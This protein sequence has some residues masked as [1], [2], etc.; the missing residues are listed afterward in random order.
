VLKVL[1]G[2]RD[3]KLQLSGKQLQISIRGHYWVLKFSILPLNSPKM[4]DIQVMTPALMDGGNVA[5]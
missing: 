5:S 2:G 4:G 3:R 1:S